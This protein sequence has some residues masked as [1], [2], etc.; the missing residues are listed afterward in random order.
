[1]AR[2]KKSGGGIQWLLLFLLI[3]ITAGLWYFFIA[4]EKE[5]P[6]P[7]SEPVLSGAD[8]DYRPVAQNV[9]LLLRRGLGD[10]AEVAW[11][12]PVEKETERAATGGK[13]RWTAANIVV[14]PTE[15]IDL[16]AIVQNI[17]P[18]QSELELLP[19]E[20]DT[21][22]GEQAERYELRLTASPDEVMLYMTIGHIYCKNVQ[23]E[24][25][26]ETKKEEPAP[27]TLQTEP[28]AEPAQPVTPAVTPP[29]KK[30]HKA[31][32]R[33]YLAIVVDDC[34]ENLAVQEV[35]ESLG[36][37]F[38]FAVIPY[39]SHTRE[40][41]VS[42]SQAGMEVILHLPM[43]SLAGEGM[44]PTS[45]LTSMDDKTIRNTVVNAIGQVPHIVGVN[46][47]QG[48]KA[49]SDKRVMKVVLNEL[50]ARN[51]Y[52]FDSRT[53][54]S[55]VASSMASSMGMRTAYNELF[56]DNSADESVIRERL[57]EAVQIAL[58]DGSC[59][60]IGHCRPHTAAAV[61]DMV[62]EIESEGV[63]LVHLSRLLR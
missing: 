6:M 2:K 53:S 34:G 50:A 61:R 55:S 7:P 4:E 22:Q 33:A 5:P 40:A 56:I 52:F 13:I 27:G 10:K 51:L 3:A 54:P 26:K 9:Y 18:S 8:A 17:T 16:A 32:T 42:G 1:M 21:W 36:R 46:N 44:E 63:E 31:A 28:P 35:Y 25:D 38:T 62:A 23:K 11:E 58:R 41:A 47:H 59:I 19:P 20:A 43:E 37:P 57:R 48:S 29:P 24:K 15:E 12:P 30:T 45:I 60:V 39:L 49:T 14:T